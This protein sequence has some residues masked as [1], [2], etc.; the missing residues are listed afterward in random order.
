MMPYMLIVILCMALNEE[1]AKSKITDYNIW[2]DGDS[3]DYKAE[4]FVGKK[5][6][7]II[8]VVAKASTDDMDKIRNL[9][10]S[11]EGTDVKVW[12]LSGSPE[13]EVENFRHE[14]QIGI[15]ALSSDTK[16]LKTI[17]RANPTLWLIK[18]GIVKGK[19]AHADV[20][21]KNEILG[22]AQ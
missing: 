10:K 11:L 20:P 18:D 19:W 8:P 16:V 13:E 9:A 1:A 21:E 3:T 15:P 4:S 6:M 5:L 17:G 12:L 7:I 14:F 22:L 2:K